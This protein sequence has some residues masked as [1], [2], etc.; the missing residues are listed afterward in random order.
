MKVRF[1]APARQEFREA[2][3]AYNAERAGLGDELRDCV[4]EAIQRIIEYPG[5]WHP[6]TG[7]IRRCRTRRFPYALI[8]EPGDGEIVLIAVAHLH[9][10]PT[11]WQERQQ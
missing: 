7:T 1:L 10:A 2:V 5:A 4:W 8:Y 11:Y 9:R 6:L 3:F